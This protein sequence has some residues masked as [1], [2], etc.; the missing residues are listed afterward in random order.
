[1]NDFNNFNNSNFLNSLTDI[2][3]MHNFN[4]EA[5]IRKTSIVGI[6]IAI[7]IIVQ[8]YST[9]ATMFNLN[10]KI[11]IKQEKY[12]ISEI[13]SMARDAWNDAVDAGYYTTNSKLDYVEKVLERKGVD[14]D[15]YNI[16]Y[17]Y[18]YGVEVEAK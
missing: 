7:V 10:Q 5:R 14:V 1:M 11:N 4:N 2:N 16:T 12:T 17:H 9:F 15:K 13:E 18:Y 8:I 6:V 3:D